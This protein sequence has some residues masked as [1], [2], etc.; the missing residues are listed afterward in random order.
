M[1]AADSYFLKKHNLMDYSLLLMVEFFDSNNQSLP[2]K[3]VRESTMLGQSVHEPSDDLVAQGFRTSIYSSTKIDNLKSVKQ[4]QPQIYHIGII[5]Y[6]QDF[7]SDKRMESF[8]K[9]KIKQGGGKQEISCVHPDW[10]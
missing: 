6:L 9:L 1:I 7:N 2:K 5:D 4:L 8:Y 3:S 10:Y